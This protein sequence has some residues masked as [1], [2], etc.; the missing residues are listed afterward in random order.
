MLCREFGIDAFATAGSEEKARAVR[1]LGATSIQYRHEV[2][3]AV[4]L[5]STGGRGV[6]VV[7]D[8]KDA[9]YFHE[10]LRALAKDGRLQLIGT[11]GGAAVDSVIS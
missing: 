4:V 3:S 2:F 5:Q 9:S 6:D 10:N 8:I 1:A 11:L 7:L